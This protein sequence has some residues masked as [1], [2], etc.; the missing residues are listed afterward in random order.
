M[1]AHDTC[2]EASC[3]RVGDRE[4]AAFEPA[5]GAHLAVADIER[6]DEP[7]AE[8]LYPRGRVG[9]GRRSD[10]HTVGACLKQRRG[11]GK[12]ADATRCLKF[13]PADCGG[14][15]RDD[16]GPH[17]AGACA[18]K[19]DKVYAARTSVG[20]GR[21]KR[22]R[23][24]GVSNDSVVVA[25]VQSNGGGAEHVDCRNDLDWPI[26]PAVEGEMRG[27]DRHRGTHHI[28][29]HIAPLPC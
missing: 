9:E 1:D 20:P 5:A 18:I 14:H 11:I 27:G 13:H 7:V 3:D 29:G 19:V 28:D 2:I 22:N 17:S 24:S 16:L 15:S 8:R 12:G 6:H 10:N 26:E 25:L 23:V 21:G 4:A